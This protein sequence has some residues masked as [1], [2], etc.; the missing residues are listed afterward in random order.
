[1]H[2]PAQ[3]TH[4]ALAHGLEHLEAGCRAV[5]IHM[6]KHRPNPGQPFDFVE[7]ITKPRS[8]D[9]HRIQPIQI[10]RLQAGEKLTIALE[11]GHDCTMRR[12]SAK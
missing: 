12:V 11:G 9:K 8:L 1:M 7:R 5:G 2:A 4:R 6:L 10:R 3:V